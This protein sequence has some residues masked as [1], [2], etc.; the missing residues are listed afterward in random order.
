MLKIHPDDNVA[1]VLEEGGENGVPFAHKVALKRIATG[2]AV[3]K[4]GAP[5]AFATR[6]IEEGEWV[7]EHNARSYFVEKLAGLREG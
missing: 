4:Y 1:V 2:E 5:I 7:H 3:V 6:D